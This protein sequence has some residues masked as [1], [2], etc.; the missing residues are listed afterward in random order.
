MS[1]LKIFLGL[2]P[3]Q[4]IFLDSVISCFRPHFVP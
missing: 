1:I 3:I 2:D 4:A